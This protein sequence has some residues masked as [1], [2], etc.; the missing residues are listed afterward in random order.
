MKPVALILSVLSMV[1]SL[2]S[3]AFVL[4][5]TYRS[6]KEL[7]DL[8]Q[9]ERS[10]ESFQW[11]KVP[12]DY[13][14]PSQGFT[15]LYA[16]TKKPFDQNLPTVLFFTGGPGVSSRST[17][18][19][20]PESNVL[21]FEQRGISCSR[22]NDRAL[23][24]NPAF[25][26]SENTARD[27]LAVM[28]AWNLK[29]ISVYGHSYGTIPA[30]IFASFYPAHTRSLILEGVVYHADESLWLAK[31][32]DQLLQNVFDSLSADER[33]KILGLSAR[34]DLPANWF[35]KIGNMMLYFNNGVQ[36]YQNFLHGILSSTDLDLKSFILN[37]YPDPKKEEEEYSFGD[38]AMAMIACKEM[39]MSNPQMSLTTV[40]KKGELVSDHLNS[41]REALCRTVTLENA[42]RVFPS[43]K[44]DR[45]PVYAP[46]T[47]LL[48]ETD[49][50]TTLDQGLSH[51][52]HVAKGDK[53]VFIMT[54]G[55]HLPSLG[56]LKDNRACTG[57]EC[58]SLKQNQ[59][60]VSFFEKLI[61][62]ESITAHFIEEFNNSGELKW[63]VHQ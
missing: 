45:Y 55:G 35:S 54:S 19:D 44:A 61:R 7:C 8:H 22:P 53:R 6:G 52:H 59:L 14:D 48:G 30:T 26:S 47:Y 51:Y 58:E 41:D 12:V 10:G 60:Q 16:Y 38:V 39:S 43:Y 17:E 21:Y 9:E 24:L 23:F 13:Q 5:S 15:D 33:E 28:K 34:E 49:G 63:N 1:L 32:R 3:Q 62:N 29:H 36:A 2:E 31:T 25:Y 27:A 42:Y 11:V 40:F 56:L 57:D 37:F 4:S 50:A 46:V 20:L 18:F